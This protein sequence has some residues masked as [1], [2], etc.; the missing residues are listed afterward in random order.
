MSKELIIQTV[1]DYLSSVPDGYIAGSPEAFICVYGSSIS[2]ALKSDS[3]VDI[4]CAIP[5]THVANIDVDELGE[6]IHDSHIKHGHRADQEVPYSNKLV[7]SFSDLRDAVTLQAFDRNSHGEVIVP[8]IKKESKFLASKQIKLRL[9]LNALT[10]PNLIICH[11]DRAAKGFSELA[12][13]AMTAV[14]ISLHGDIRCSVNDVLE[15][16]YMSSAST[17]GEMFLGYKSER[18]SVT[19]RLRFIIVRSLYTLS[20]HGGLTVSTDELETYDVDPSF[21]AFQ[22]M[23]A[24]CSAFKL[25]K[26]TL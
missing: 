25:K 9:G 15:A 22:E 23:K 16:L 3:D 2:E 11:E 4:L 14:G 10:T 20:L 1:T 12:G 19:S 17:S 18:A 21:D 8:E 26:S 7:Y 13:L 24:I 5:D 6:L